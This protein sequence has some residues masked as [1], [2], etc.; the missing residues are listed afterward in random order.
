MTHSDTRQP[1]DNLGTTSAGFILIQYVRDVSCGLG[2]GS[3]FRYPGPDTGIGYGAI[4]PVGLCYIPP[5]CGA[6]IRTCSSRQPCTQNAS[7]Q[8]SGYARS[9]ACCNS[10]TYTLNT[11]CEATDPIAAIKYSHTDVCYFLN[12]KAEISRH[13]R[14]GLHISGRSHLS[15]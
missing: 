15:V 14:S 12:K 2:L 6:M 4:S 8:I 1:V 13:L 5:S 11:M 3:V 10:Y 9:S 7:V